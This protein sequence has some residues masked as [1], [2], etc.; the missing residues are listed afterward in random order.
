MTKQYMTQITFA[1]VPRY[2]N[3]NIILKTMTIHVNH[4]IYI[5]IYTSQDEK[6][7]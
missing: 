4:V 2:D 1:N 5:Y 3:K 7:G 6:A